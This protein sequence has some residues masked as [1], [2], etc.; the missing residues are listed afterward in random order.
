M[1]TFEQANV[2]YFAR[3]DF[4][5]E[6]VSFRHDIPFCFCLAWGL[7]KKNFWGGGMSEGIGRKVYERHFN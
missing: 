4:G 7:H 1:A 2:F 3:L 6:G 5:V